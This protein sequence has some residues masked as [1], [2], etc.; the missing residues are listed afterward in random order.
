MF[1][2]WSIASSI[3]PGL[4]KYLLL[5]IPD[6]YKYGS[7]LKS[8]LSGGNYTF[9]MLGIGFL[10]VLPAKGRQE[11]A[12][13]SKPLRP[14]LTQ[15]GTVVSRGWYCKRNY[16]R[17]LGGTGIFPR[18]VRDSLDHG[19]SSKEGPGLPGVQHQDQLSLYE[20]HVV[21]ADR[22]VHGRRVARGKVDE[23][24]HGAVGNDDARRAVDQASICG[25]V[26][27]VC[28]V[29]DRLSGPIAKGGL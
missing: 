13:S 2:F 6:F 11:H 12:M 5:L 27:A 7:C 10:F 23:T 28:D 24:A 3:C 4:S 21:D 22:A 9:L 15:I 18:M 29:G 14:S 1:Q 19:V 16:P 25:N 20:A 26:L 17:P 8:S